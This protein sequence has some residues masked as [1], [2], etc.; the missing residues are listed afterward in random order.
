MLLLLYVIAVIVWGT[1]DGRADAKANPDPDRRA[2]L[3]MTWLV[4]GLVAGILSGA[5]AW[6]IALFYKGIYVGGLINEVTTFAAFTALI[7]FLPGISGV[8]VG[9]WRVD[10]NAPRCPPTT[11]PA[12]APTLMCSPRC[13]PTTVLPGRCRWPPTRR[14][15]RLPPRLPPSNAMPRPR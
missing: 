2:D 10:R 15:Q 14:R 8:A 12:A 1:L 7:I 3:A 9:R 13:A 5:V 11:E 4:A 6:I